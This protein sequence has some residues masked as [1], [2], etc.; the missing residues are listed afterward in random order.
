MRKEQIVPN[1]KLKEKASD[2][3]ALLYADGNFMPNTVRSPDCFIFQNKN[4]F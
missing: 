4:C 1:G 2:S 3:H